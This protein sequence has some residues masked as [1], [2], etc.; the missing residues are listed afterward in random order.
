MKK[1]LGI[2]LVTLPFIGV[3]ILGCFMIGIYAVLACHG[4]CAIIVGMVYYGAYLIDNE[5]ES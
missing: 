4:I 1:I 2:I 3:F 5:N